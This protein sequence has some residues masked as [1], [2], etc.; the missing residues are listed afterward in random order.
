MRNIDGY[1]R[2]IQVNFFCQQG[3]FD[4]ENLCTQEYQ[5]YSYPILT[6]VAYALLG[7]F[8]VVNL[9]YAKPEGTEGG[10]IAQVVLR[11]HN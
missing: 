2:K 6:A 7:I 10:S 5:K 9:V 11:N 4:P 3:G 1:I 8:P